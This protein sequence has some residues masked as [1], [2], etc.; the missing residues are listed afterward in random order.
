M[1]ELVGYRLYFEGE[2]WEGGRVFRTPIPAWRIY[3][4]QV[5]WHPQLRELFE[6]RELGTDGKERTLEVPDLVALLKPPAGTYY[7]VFLDD[8]PYRDGQR[9]RT[10]GG[11]WRLY[12]RVLENRCIYVNRLNVREISPAGVRILK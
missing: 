8:K 6:V 2:P 1:S 4:R 10:E 5:N 9:F 12:D 11:A 3:Q 7:Q